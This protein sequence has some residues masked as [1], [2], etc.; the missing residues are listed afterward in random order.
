MVTKFQKRVYELC[1]KVP[2]G[3]VT[4]Y[5]A[6]CKKMRTK[7]YRAVGT[8]LNKNPFAPRVPCHR[9]VNSNGFVGQ[10]AKGI[11]TKIKLLKKEGI[12]IK[13]NKIE[14]FDKILVK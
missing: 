8:A 1:K 12:K 14:D 4:T 9:V 10:F 7:A 3:R 13:N 2:K 11:N 5:K 6:I